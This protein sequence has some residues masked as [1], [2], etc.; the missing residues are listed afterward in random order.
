MSEERVPASS[1]VVNL[2]NNRIVKTNG[3]DSLFNAFGEPL[4][5]FKVGRDGQLLVDSEVRD[6]S[7]NL[8][9]TIRNNSVVSFDGSSYETYGD[10]R[11][12]G[13]RHKDSK[14]IIFERR[15]VGRLELTILGRFQVQNRTILINENGIRILPQEIVLAGNFKE[16]Q[17]EAINITETG[18]EF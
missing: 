18:F 2:G 1:Y 17:Y 4:F 9:A 10:A 15:I 14:E 5:T 11:I 12:T 8:L 3:T 13:V 6:D 7:Q 16:T